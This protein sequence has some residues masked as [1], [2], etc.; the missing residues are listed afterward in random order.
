M[1][2][3]MGEKKLFVNLFITSCVICFL[4]VLFFFVISKLHFKIKV[5][6][7]TENGFCLSTF[8][9]LQA[10]YKLELFFNLNPIYY[11]TTSI[12]ALT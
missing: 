9:F 4:S 5:I 7:L 11:N 1:E 12:M 8:L 3:G 2:E 10:L 6:S